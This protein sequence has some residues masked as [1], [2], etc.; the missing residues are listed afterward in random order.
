MTGG[1]GVGNQKGESERVER[2]GDLKETWRGLARE[3]EGAG[4]EWEGLPKGRKKTGL[5]IK[6]CI[7]I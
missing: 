2:K 1:K 6:G 4:G 5:S 3:G 7:A